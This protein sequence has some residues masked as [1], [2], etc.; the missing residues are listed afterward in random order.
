MTQ[1]ND[2][3]LEDFDNYIASIGAIDV[4]DGDYR[5]CSSVSDVKEYVLMKMSQAFA[6]GEASGIAKAEKC[7]PDAEIYDK[8]D[9]QI[10]QDVDYTLGNVKDSWNA[11]RLKMLTNIAKLKNL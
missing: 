9:F 5:V 11:C 7:V 3:E 8:D 4:D 10:A 2:S 1:T 6:A